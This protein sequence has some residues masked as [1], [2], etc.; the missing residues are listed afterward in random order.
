VPFFVVVVV[1][2]DLDVVDQLTGFLFCV[3]GRQ[4]GVGHKW[5]IGVVSLIDKETRWEAVVV[6]EGIHQNLV[7][8][9]KM[10]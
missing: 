2:L 8:V 1:C 7:S 10:P 9:A 6:L 4:G 3:E 5:L